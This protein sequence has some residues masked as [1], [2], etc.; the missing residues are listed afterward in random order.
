MSSLLTYV[1]E[2]D[3]ANQQIQN[4][5][6]PIVPITKGLAILPIIGDITGTRAQTIIHIALSYSQEMSLTHLVIDLSGIL[7]IDNTISGYLLSMVNMLRLVGVEPIL[8]GFRPDMAIKA[9]E[10]NIDLGDV[11]IYSNVREALSRIGL[12]ST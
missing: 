5:S 1:L 12:A 10:I 6:A 8:T 9:H 11:K 3:Q 4:L 2:L 7:K